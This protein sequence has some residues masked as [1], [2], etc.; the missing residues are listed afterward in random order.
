MLKKFRLTRPNWK[1]IQS[2][3]LEIKMVQSNKKFLKYCKNF[4]RIFWTRYF[5]NLKCLIYNKAKS[6]HQTIDLPNSDRLTW[7]VD[8]APLPWSFDNTK[9]SPSIVIRHP[10]SWKKIH[11]YFK[12]FKKMF[13]SYFIVPPDFNPSNAFWNFSMTKKLTN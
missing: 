11:H 7:I 4:N 6:F 10:F 2:P 5:F 12:K 9:F 3:W 13:I 1:S 8:S